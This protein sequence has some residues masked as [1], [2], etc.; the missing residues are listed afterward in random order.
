MSTLYGSLAELPLM[1]TVG[2]AGE[3]LRISRTTAYKLIE[4]HRSTGGRAG[5]VHAG[6]SSAAS[7]SRRSRAP[8]RTLCEPAYGGG[9][10]RRTS[11]M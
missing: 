1:L 8:R 3:V 5:L 6:S 9:S 4:L 7:T 11:A 2:E 10:A